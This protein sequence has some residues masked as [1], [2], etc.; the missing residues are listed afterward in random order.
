M[1]INSE[2]QQEVSESVLDRRTAVCIVK[3]SG[4][5]SEAFRGDIT[6][7]W[8]FSDS[9]MTPMEA[10]LVG[11]SPHTLQVSV[12]GK[13]LV[14]R[15]LQMSQPPRKRFAS[16]V[17]VKQTPIISCLALNRQPLVGEGGYITNVLV[18]IGSVLVGPGIW[19]EVGSLVVLK[20]LHRCY[21]TCSVPSW[22][23]S[24]IPVFHSHLTGCGRLVLTLAGAASVDPPWSG[25]CFV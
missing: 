21:R 12:D 6:V 5:P 7:R 19:S 14:V 25:S 24:W 9:I 15:N 11:S 2:R 16:A 22:F 23:N 1:L 13:T 17:T 18:A 10:I 3:P 8:L 4:E 20:E